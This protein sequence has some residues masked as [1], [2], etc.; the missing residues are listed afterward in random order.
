M[1]VCLALLLTVAS[2]AENATNATSNVSNVT[3]YFFYLET[4]P[5]CHDAAKFLDSIKDK[6]Q[7]EIKKFEVTD[8]RN[9]QY[10]ESF[11]EHYNVTKPWGAVP[12]IFIGDTYIIGY[13]SDSTEG[14]WLEDNISKCAQYGCRDAGE[15]IAYPAQTSSVSTYTIPLLIVVAVLLVVVFYSVKMKKKKQSTKV[16]GRRKSD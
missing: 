9:A 6:Y 5:H 11:S 7:F 8:R 13:S 12:A 14:K 16:K 3:L 2:A 10:F 15:G 1:L 4:C